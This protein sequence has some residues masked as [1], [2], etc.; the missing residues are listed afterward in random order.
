M[1]KTRAVF[2]TAAALAIYGL[3]GCNLPTAAPTRDQSGTA[4]AGIL[5]ASETDAVA[6]ATA[7][8]PAPAPSTPTNTA[9][10]TVAAFSPTP[11]SPLVKV[12]TLCW[13]GPGNAYEVVSAIRSGTPVELLGQG[14]VPGWYVVR[15]PIYRDPC[16]IRAS[17]LQVSLSI[18]LAGLPYFNPPPTPTET[19]KPEPTNTP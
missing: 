4:D 18:N 13:E 5:A 9:T 16:W 6:Q 19:P 15:N 12:D 11:E 8:S 10:A 14:T 7:V 17:D 1:Q 3:I 2:A